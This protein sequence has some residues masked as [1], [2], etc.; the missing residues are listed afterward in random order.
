VSTVTQPIERILVATNGS[1]GAKAAV[2]LGVDLAGA[3]DAQLV[4]LHVRPAAVWRY[5]RLA[6]ASA[7]PRKLGTPLQDEALCEASVAASESGMQA[8]LELLS[9][10]AAREIVTVADIVDADLIVVGESRR[11]PLRERVGYEVLRRSKRPVLVARRQRARE[12]V[13]RP[14]EL[15]KAA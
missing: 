5:A 4:F 14:K 12:A 2:K 1:K 9:G 7:I 13:E 11:N 3:H 10:D 6:P 8:H 15:A